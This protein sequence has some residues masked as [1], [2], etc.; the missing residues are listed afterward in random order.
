MN[1]FQR[2]PDGHLRCEDVPLE[3]IA[4]EVGTP[5]YVYSHAT[6][7]RHARVWRDAW[8][9]VEHQGCFAVKACSSLGILDVIARAGLGFDIVS[10]GELRRVL[11]VG[12][13]PSKVVFSGVGKTL[14]ELRLAL[15]VGIG[16]FNVESPAEL[17]Q[18]ASVARALGKRAPVSLRVNPDVDAETHPYIATGLKH[19]KFGIAWGDAPEVYA[20]AAALPELEVIGVDCHIGSQLSRT[21][22][23]V[24]ALDRLLA[25]VDRLVAMG[26][27]IRQVDI[28]GGL[29]ITYR[30]E[31][32][33]SPDEYAAR[34]RERLL[35]SGHPLRILT[36]P[37]RVLV[38]NA[39]CLVTRCLLVKDN[40]DTR[41]V[42]VDAGMNDL[43][44][45]A[46]Y[47]AWHAI[48]PVAPPRAETAVVDVVG[49]VCE[50]GDF[51]ARTRE[52]PRIEAGELVCVRSAGAYGFVM[53]SNYNS[54]PRA[55]EVLVDG[56][57]YD[58]IRARETFD[59]L[60]RG[61]RV[62]GRA[63]AT[64][65]PAGQAGQAGEE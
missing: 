16:C 52:L 45:P 24:A 54:R 62:P 41:F 11:A 38:G 20:R 25:L 3:V 8:D 64:L 21:E 33:P 51:L 39:G 4:R 15:E 48:E 47:Q 50:T 35:A 10:G 14:D 34:V 32:P 49:P 7:A 60:V 18:L 22:P 28:G 55:A 31:Q 57:R 13:D 12:G 65:G 30:E 29:G 5:V 46:L 58:V 26:I 59:D 1:H 37:G 61:E 42:V 19:S 36:E 44:R 53:A 23:F 2:G 17:E 56:D 43:L 6:I 9:G 40:G 27:P 63:A